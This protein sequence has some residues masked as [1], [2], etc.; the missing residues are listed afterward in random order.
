[1]IQRLPPSLGAIGPGGATSEHSP[2][3]ATAASWFKVSGLGEAVRAAEV[4]LAMKV[5]YADRRP[6]SPSAAFSKGS[7]LTQILH[8]HGFQ[9]ASI[10]QQCNTQLNELVRKRGRETHLATARAALLFTRSEVERRIWMAAWRTGGYGAQGAGADADAEDKAV[11]ELAEVEVEGRS[12]CGAV[13]GF[14]A[15]T[16]GAE[17]AGADAED[18]AVTEL[19]EVEVEGRS[20]CG[21]VAGFMADTCGS[22]GAGADAEDAG[23]TELT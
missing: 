7:T 22:E 10:M 1:M 4:R 15:D 3:A 13:A 6:H 11:T 14:M 2:P 5:N 8:T 9:P 20:R 12:R 18:K 17:G 16:C 23:V 19:A 21:A